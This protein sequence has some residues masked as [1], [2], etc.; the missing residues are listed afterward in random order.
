MHLTESLMAASGATD[1]PTY[2]QMG[3]T[4]RESHRWS[5]P[6]SGQRSRRAVEACLAGADRFAQRR[7]SRHEPDHAGPAFSAG[8]NNSPPK[9]WRGFCA[10]I[11]GPRASRGSILSIGAYVVAL[12][13]EAPPSEA[14]AE[15][16]F[17]LLLPKE[18]AHSPSRRKR[19]FHLTLT[20]QEPRARA[21]IS[22]VAGTEK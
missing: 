1:D 17:L 16:L 13:M 19:C 15:L 12:T 22:P 18:R 14:S 20:A 7:G 9:V 11:R 21:A 8:R 10:A 2:I 5:A 3:E 4:N 6:I